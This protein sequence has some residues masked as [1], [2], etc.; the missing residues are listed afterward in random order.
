MSTARTSFFSHF[1]EN[2]NVKAKNK[3]VL[4]EDDESRTDIVVESLCRDRD[5]GEGQG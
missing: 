2:E 3:L 1:D 4:R 5:R